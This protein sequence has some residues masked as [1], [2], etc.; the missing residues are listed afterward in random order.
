MLNVNE[1]LLTCFSFKDASNSRH[2]SLLRMEAFFRRVNYEF[3]EKASSEN[4]SV[5]H[6]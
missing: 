2:S 3:F 6:S 4:D 5:S 1:V